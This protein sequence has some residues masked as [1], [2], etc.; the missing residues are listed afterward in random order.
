M[1]NGEAVR[2]GASAPLRVKRVVATAEPEGLIA[3]AIHN[4][5]ISTTVRAGLANKWSFQ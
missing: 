5:S 3:K 4:Y 2:C 1:V